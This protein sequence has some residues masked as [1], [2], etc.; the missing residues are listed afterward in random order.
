VKTKAKR[1]FWE[2]TPVKNIATMKRT[3]AHMPAARVARL[4]D[5]PE[6]YTVEEVAEHFKVNK[7]TIYHWKGVWIEAETD[8]PTRFTAQQIEDCK[9]RRKANHPLNNRKHG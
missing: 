2:D 9:V 6:L 4:E 7:F 3:H 8:R 5:M 1:N